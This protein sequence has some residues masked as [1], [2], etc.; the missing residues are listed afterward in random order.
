[1]ILVYKFEGT[2][3][4]FLC[5]DEKVLSDVLPTMRKCSRNCI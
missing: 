4:S 5:I 2:V 3:S 1:M